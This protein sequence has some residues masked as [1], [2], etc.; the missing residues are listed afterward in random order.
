MERVR[1]DAESADDAFDAFVR[2][3]SRSLHRTAY[4]MTGDRERAQDVVQTALAKLYQAWPRRAEWEHPLAYARQ[5]VVSTVLRSAERRWWGEKPTEHL[6]ERAGPG[7]DHDDVTADRDE[8]RRALAALP[9][10]QR[11]A[12]VL[13]YYLDLSEAAT[14]DAMA[15]PPGTVKSLTSRGLA[16]LRTSLT[17][18]NA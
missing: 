18:A 1:D 17:E 15:C 3:N 8:L 7:T 12:V 14:A 11:S 2:E 4:L 9:V 13:R 16:A 5:A 6:P 10:R